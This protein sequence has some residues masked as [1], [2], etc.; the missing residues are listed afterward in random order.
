M[1][2]DSIPYESV[3]ITETHP[4][5][6]AM[7]GRLFGLDTA[8]PEHCRVLELGCAS[9]GNLLPMASRS[10]GSEFVGLDLSALQIHNGQ[11][12]IARLGLKNIH[13]LQG[14]L[15]EFEDRP[16]SFD[17]IIAHGLYSWVPLAV[18]D[19]LLGK[20]K[21]LLAPQGIAY[22]SYNT[23]PGWGSRGIL[24]SMAL[25]HVRDIE[26]P[27]AR[28]QALMELFEFLRGYYQTSKNPLQQQLYLELKDLESAHPS[29]L[30]HDFLEANNDAILFS[31]FAEHIATHQ[32]KYLCESELHTMFASTL[33]PAGER[34]LDAYDDMLV[35][36]QYIDY[37]RLRTFRMSLLVHEESSVNYD[38]SL[39][40]LDDYALYSSLQAPSKLHLDTT[41][42][43]SFTRPDGKPVD[44]AQPLT[45]LSLQILY[46]ETPGAMSLQQLYQ[47]AQSQLP[48][49]KSSGVETDPDAYRSELFNLFVNGCIRFVLS[50]R[51]RTAL[52]SETPCLT[53]LAA[54]ELAAGDVLSGVWHEPVQ[55]D[56]FAR[57]LAAQMDGSKNLPGIRTAILDT[58]RRDPELAA[59]LNIDTRVAEKRL[60]ATLDS[61]IKRLLGVFQRQELLR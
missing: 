42:P 39:S 48:V 58:L 9:G 21:Q 49:V 23:L 11:E 26:E 55:L 36:E 38:V 41:R 8:R 14:D 40:L 29:Y 27:V 43:V 24:R 61:N 46:D 50:P 3:P 2:Y 6:L 28:L 54:A 37:L 25:Y 20:I 35:Q 18:R 44:V 12:S 5:R 34:F 52:D 57:L 17:Y 51:P 4:Q 19:A 45:K 33:P 10:P 53:E 22:I 59:N 13:L 32:L 31:D 47:Q 16:G 56:G 15:C 7:L 60:V 30:Y 1:D